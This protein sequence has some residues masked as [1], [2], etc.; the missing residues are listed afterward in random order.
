V[1]ERKSSNISDK[2]HRVVI[3]A[4]AQLSCLLYVAAYDVEKSFTVDKKSLNHKSRALSNLCAN[5]L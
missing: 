4:I 2:V 1:L 5:T 3:F